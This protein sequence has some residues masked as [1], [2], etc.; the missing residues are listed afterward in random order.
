MKIT[1]KRFV[2]IALFV[3][4]LLFFL[5][6][7]TGIN[8]F[9]RLSTLTYN[10]SLDAIEDTISMQDH[11]TILCFLGD[12]IEAKKGGFFNLNQKIYKEFYGYRPFQII[13]IY[14]E[15]SVTDV[16][17]LSSDLGTFTDMYKWNFI[18]MDRETISELHANLK[19]KDILNTSLYSKK[20]Y[21]IDK[22]LSLRGRDKDGDDEKQI[23]YGYNIE[24]VAELNNKMEDD[25]KVLLYEYRAAFKNKNKAVR[26]N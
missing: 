25:I 17:K 19:T 26:K 7:S 6:L 5:L 24:S 10:V 9:K 8:N 20:V 23:L 4:P 1:K 21:L 18:S 14:P 16:E 15:A 22:K 11:V 3:F 13:A 2:L 12:N